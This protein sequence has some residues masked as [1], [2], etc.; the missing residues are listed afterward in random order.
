MATPSTLPPQAQAQAQ[1][2][3]QPSPQP[4]PTEGYRSWNAANKTVKRFACDRCHMQKLKCPRR[5]AS[6]L[7]CLRCVKLG[8]ASTCVYSPTL[9]FGRPTTDSCNQ[10]HI[11]TASKS[12][13]RV[14]ADQNIVLDTGLLQPSETGDPAGNPAGNQPTPNSGDASSRT[15]AGIQV[16]DLDQCP[17]YMSWTPTD[18]P[19]AAAIDKDAN[20]MDLFDTLDRSATM[21]QDDDMGVS[22]PASAPASIPGSTE[23]GFSMEWQNP[24]HNPSLFRPPP[25][26]HNSPASERSNISSAETCLT[27]LAELHLSL[28]Q[29]HQSLSSSTASPMGN[30]HSRGTNG[31]CPSPSF[32]FKSPTIDLNSIFAAA[33]QLIDCIK[34]L[35]WEPAPQEVLS[36]DPQPGMLPWSTVASA[37]VAYSHDSTNSSFS[38][39]LAD[40][41]LSVSDDVPGGGFQNPDSATFFLVLSCYARLMDIVTKILQYLKT[42]ADN[43]ENDRREFLGSVQIG[44][45]RVP[46]SS[47]LQTAIMLQVFCHLFQRAHQSIR[48]YIA[49]QGKDDS[50]LAP[51]LRLTE[52]TIKEDIKRLK[53]RLKASTKL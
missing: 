45:F 4:S 17:P 37:P 20:D 27:R 39:S 2:Q 36:S 6:E 18:R 13:Q 35:A 3:P 9:R 12:S 26:L 31:S 21:Q 15:N 28:F 42:G 25:P 33:E 38:P 53:Q 29:S 48:L 10:N 43:N 7:P 1:P 44:A 46:S 32:L 8:L 23:S 50:L 51:G 16:E 47:D 24:F 14:T 34:F 40:G 11:R 30:Q 19:S 52:C 41:F 49:A 22:A 5:S